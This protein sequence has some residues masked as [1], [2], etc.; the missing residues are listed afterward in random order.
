[1]N[2][3]RNLGARHFVDLEKAR[4]LAADNDD[5]TLFHLWGEVLGED[6]EVTRRELGC[7]ICLACPLTMIAVALWLML[8]A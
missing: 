4:P 3:Y 1:M 2:A 7:L 5:R 8:P 6:P